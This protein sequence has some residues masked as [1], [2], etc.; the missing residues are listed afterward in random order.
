MFVQVSGVC[1]GSRQEVNVGGR[2]ETSCCVSPQSREGD[3]DQREICGEEICA[4][5]LRCGS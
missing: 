2:A 5:E 4:E 1:Y 3:V